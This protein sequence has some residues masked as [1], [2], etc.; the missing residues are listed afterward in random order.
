MNDKPDRFEESARIVD[1]SAAGASDDEFELLGRI[2][3]AIR[4]RAIA[5]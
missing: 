2:A 4:D 5:E 3:E 1:A